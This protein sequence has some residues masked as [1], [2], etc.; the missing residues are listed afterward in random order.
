MS[1]TH[2]LISARAYE[3]W[4]N[5]GRPADRS[6]THWLQAERDVLA[7]LAKPVADAQAKP[8]R[9]PRKRKAATTRR[10]KAA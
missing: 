3:F 1:H 4:E 7:E 10:R 8:K 6:A 9:A 5:E 2:T